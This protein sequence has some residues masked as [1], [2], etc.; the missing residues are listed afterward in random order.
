MLNSVEQAQ[1]SAGFQRMLNGM[2]V[3]DDLELIK[4]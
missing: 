2:A 4:K 3:N 1:Q